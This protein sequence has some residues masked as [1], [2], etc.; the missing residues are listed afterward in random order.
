MKRLKVS[1]NGKVVARKA[2]QNHF[3]SKESGRSQI[4]KGRSTTFTMSNKYRSL[5]LKN[6]SKPRTPR[7]TKAEAVVEAK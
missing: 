1:K 3:N 5:F 7:E 2:G 4:A 6:T